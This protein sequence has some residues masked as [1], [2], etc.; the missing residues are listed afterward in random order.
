MKRRF[1]HFSRQSGN[2]LLATLTTVGIIGITM[3]AYLDVT[4]NQNLAVARSQSY[5]MSIAIAEAGIEEALTQLK[6]SYPGLQANSWASNYESATSVF[7]KSR[8]LPEGR[9]EAAIHGLSSPTL[10]ATGY[11]TIP[12]QTNELKRVV[13]VTTTSGSLWARGLVAKGAISIG[14]GVVDSFD[15]LGTLSYSTSI[16]K[17]GGDTGST[18][19]D[20]TVGSNGEIHGKAS[21][22]PGHT[23]TSSGD[24]GPIGSTGNDAAYMDYTLNASI[25][26]VTL[27]SGVGPS[28]GTSINASSGYTWNGTIASGIYRATT[29]D[30]KIYVTNGAQV[31]IYVSGNVTMT[32]QEGI[33]ISTNSSLTIYMAGSSMAL[34]GNGVMNSANSTNFSVY[35]MTTMTSLTI[36]GNGL[37]V[38]TFYCPQAD[39]TLNG[40]GTS[41]GMSGAACVKTA[42][43]NGNGTNFHYDENLGKI[44]NGGN[45]TISS[46][47]EI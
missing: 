12:M 26:D 34:G 4:S 6:V 22:S 25:S 43:F 7:R 8:T 44:N 32:G 24:I 31:V 38:G 36:G 45:F 47:N 46:W 29:L 11:V 23:I 21:V 30:G 17:S 37:T 41:G 1:G 20:I 9:Y 2:A 13:R 5:N 18:L 19:S 42:T 35:G 3:A 16:A 15:S 14:N 40:S 33:W 39:M 27:P 28:S 10:Y